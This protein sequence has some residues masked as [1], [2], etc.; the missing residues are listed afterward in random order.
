[1]TKNE[2]FKLMRENPA[3]YLATVEGDQPRVRGMLLYRADDDGI[4]FHTSNIKDVYKQIMKN[5]KCEMCFFGKG[6][7]VRATGTLELIEDEELIKEIYEHPSRQFLR[8]WKKQGFFEN[9]I[10]GE[11]MLLKV[12]ALKNAEVVCWSMG[13]NFSEK[14]VIKL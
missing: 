3:F 7:Q 2:I 1:M 13:D 14:K 11:K 8:D 12:F 10:N 6:T 4:I 9:E 5:S